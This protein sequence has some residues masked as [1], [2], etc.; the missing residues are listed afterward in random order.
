[1]THL[2]QRG[3]KVMHF[4]AAFSFMC[5][6]WLIAVPLRAVG[7]TDGSQQQRL[8]LAEWVCVCEGV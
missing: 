4:W 7:S 5:A 1:M 3:G 2:W 6:Q 8:S